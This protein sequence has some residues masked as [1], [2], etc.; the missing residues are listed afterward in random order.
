MWTAPVS[1]IRYPVPGT[2]YQVPGYQVPGVAGNGADSYLLV[3][4]ITPPIP[5]F[6]PNLAPAC[7]MS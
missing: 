1:D 7:V 5:P 2:R 4:S 6:I 3:T